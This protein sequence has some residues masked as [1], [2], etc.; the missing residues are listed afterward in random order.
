MIYL[1][2]LSVQVFNIVLC[3]Y[4]LHKG[5][6]YQMHLSCVVCR[7]KIEIKVI[8]SMWYIKIKPNAVIMLNGGIAI[9]IIPMN[10]RNAAN[11]SKSYYFKRKWNTNGNQFD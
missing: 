11:E 9:M 10:S 3:H 5:T 6:E 7:I 1:I 4:L 2:I 8:G